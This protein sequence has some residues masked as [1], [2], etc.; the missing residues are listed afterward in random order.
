MQPAGSGGGG[1][2]DPC[3]AG[4]CKVAVDVTN[5][6]ITPKPDPLPVH[7]ENN[8]FWELKWSWMY[9][10]QDDN[11]VKLKTESPVFDGAKK[12]NDST[13][14]MHDKGD[15]GTYPYAIKVQHWVMFQWVDCSPLD[16]TIVNG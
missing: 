6:V 1:L 11:A 4:E 13:F 15:K 5:C 12:L 2:A 7:G 8:I 3:N 10:F 14:K 16:P 9:R